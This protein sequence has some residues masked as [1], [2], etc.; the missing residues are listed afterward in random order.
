MKYRVRVG[1]EGEVY[2]PRNIGRLEAQRDDLV[3]EL[4]ADAIGRI[5]EISI[6]RKVP[7]DRVERFRSTVG[8]GRGGSKVAFHV[9]GD[10]EL[11]DRLL[12]ELQRFES[13][14]SFGVRGAVKRFVWHS[15][16]T[17]IIAESPDEQAVVPI[18]GFAF[19]TAYPDPKWL[20]KPRGL[21][22]ILDDP[23]Y[24]SL[25]VPKAFWREGVAEFH[26]LRYIQA[27]YN[28]YFILEDFYADGAFTKN[29]TL[30][31][32][33]KSNEFNAITKLALKTLPSS[34]RKQFERLNALA[35]AMKCGELNDVQAAWKLL[36]AIP[37]R[38]HHFTSKGGFIRGTPYNQRDFEAPA[39]FAMYLASCA[40]E[41]RE[42]A[43]WRAAAEKG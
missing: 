37:G 29:E 42:K 12:L 8:P 18:T 17:E 11:F 3:F 10:K 4:T 2:L 43:G 39:F 35:K 33:R 1:V 25:A 20:V 22:R 34:S 30:N 24:E 16:T 6:A 7:Q 31:R 5:T 13:A 38:L 26:H 14:L 32:F 40:V 19:K 21:Q 15:Y 36:V 41:T 9:G 27:Y 28:F 23:S